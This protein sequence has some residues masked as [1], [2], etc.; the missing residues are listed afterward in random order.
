MNDEDGVCESGRNDSATPQTSL[1]DGQME[2][3]I[4]V[5]RKRLEAMITGSVHS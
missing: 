1:V 2:E 4:Q 3:R 5:D